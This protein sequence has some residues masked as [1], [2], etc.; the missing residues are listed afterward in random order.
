MKSKIFY[1]SKNAAFEACKS[2]LFSSNCSIDSFNFL[3]GNI[4][5]SKS[6]GFLTYGHKIFFSIKEI[7]D[8]QVEINV[9][10]NSI[11]LQIID[12]NTNSNLEDNLLQSVSNILL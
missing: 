12:W 7:R 8:T 2:A 11:G 9:T 5:A 4:I 10:S 3:S 6:G 1:V